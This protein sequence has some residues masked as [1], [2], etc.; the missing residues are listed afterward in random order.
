MTLRV[1]ASGG[2][3]AAAVP[4]PRHLRCC[5]GAHA[6]GGSVRVGPETGMRL[7]VS[8]PFRGH[9]FCHLLLGA[10]I[11]QNSGAQPKRPGRRE[12]GCWNTVYLFAS[13]GLA[14]EIQPLNC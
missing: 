7:L 3:G 2:V 4:L 8:G 6:A 11:G 12:H 13:C 14:V 9:F 5:A 1:F 10:S